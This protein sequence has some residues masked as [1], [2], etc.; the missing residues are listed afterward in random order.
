LGIAPEIRVFDRST[1][2]AA[3]AAAAIGCPVAAIAKTLVFRGIPA[4]AGGKTETPDTAGPGDRLVVI[5][6]SGANRVDT[7]RVSALLAPTAGPLTIAKAG[8]DWVR[9]MTGYAI[10]GVA[11]IGPVTAALSVL[12]I[13]LADREEVWAAAGTPN[14]VARFT[15]P[16]LARLTGAAVGPVGPAGRTAE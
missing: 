1:R 7:D 14:R 8:A 2:T 16:A 12:D 6:A 10:G 13:D 11:P 4:A 15:G 9:S 3:D 5:V